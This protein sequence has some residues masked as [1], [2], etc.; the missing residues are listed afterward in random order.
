MTGPTCQRCGARLASSAVDALCAACLLQ[1][2]L[3]TMAED[4]EQPATLR[5]PRD[6]GPYRLLEEIGRGGMGVVYRAEQTGLGRLVAVK[7]LLAGA[8]SAETLLRRFHLEA[9]AIAALQHPN[10]VAIHDYGEV[11]GQP[12]YAM[13]LVEGRDLAA[14]CGGRPLPARAAAENLRLLAEAVHYA[15]QHGILHR[16][17]KP[18]NVLVDTSGRPRIADF[19][20]AKQLGSPEGGTLAG[21][22]LG[23]PSYT[24]PEQASGHGEKIDV[25]SDVYGLG[26]LLY[27]L[28]TGRAPFNAASPTETLRLVLDTDPAPPRLLNPALPAD[29]E[30]ICLKCLEKEPGRRYATAAD[31]A[32]DLQRYLDERPILARPPSVWYRM[33]KF[34]RRHRAGVGMTAAV[35]F[36]LTLGLGLAL[37]G[38]HRELVLRQQAEAARAEAER[39]LGMMMQD[40]KPALEE[41]AA[42]APLV[43]MTEAAVR[44]Y[45]QLPARL[46]NS[47]TDA[48]HADALAALARLR[49]LQNDR[50]GAEAALAAALEL[51]AR[52]A[53]KN[54]QD[55]DAAAAWLRDRWDQ[56]RLVANLTRYQSLEWHGEFYRRWTELHR[57]FPGNARVKRGLAEVAAQYAEVAAFFDAPQESIAAAQLSRKLVGELQAAAPGDASLDAVAFESLRS[58]SSGYGAV[59]DHD[60]MLATAE[61]AVSFCTAAW[62]KDPANLALRRRL[63]EAA[64][65]LSFRAS[66]VSP[67]RACAAERVA[68][69]HFRILAE[70]RPGDMEVYSRYVHAHSM[71]RLYWVNHDGDRASAHAFLDRYEQLLA[72][73]PPAT[74]EFD[75]TELRTAN[76]I[77]RAQ[78]FARAGDDPR[79]REACRAA[80]ASLEVQIDRM[81]ADPMKRRLVRIRTLEWLL[82]VDIDLGDWPGLAR[83]AQEVSDL[84]DAGLQLEPEN[85]ELRVRSLQMPLFRGLAQQGLGQSA[86]AVAILEEAIPRLRGVRP[87]AHVYDLYGTRG[88]AR[89]ALIAA[90]AALGN[91][92]AAREQAE[93][94]L[95]VVGPNVDEG[96]YQKEFRARVQTLLAG[97]LASDEAGR[98]AELLATGEALLTAPEAGPR[99]TQS[100]R[101]T[102]EKI[103]ALR[104]AAGPSTG[105]TVPAGGQSSAAPPE[106]RPGGPPAGI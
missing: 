37:R 24:P 61:E 33:R 45:D 28:L 64:R 68:R 85:A 73:M 9:A 87:T 75:V 39:L 78:L 47:R 22:M 11:D 46:R 20:L 69:E 74:E 19:G 59:R 31:L 17:L 27:H 80:R 10:I 97:V 53:Q 99:L 82:W 79:C 57:R 62:Q 86:E 1:S 103:A 4:G 6:F 98:A 100:G 54:P 65:A 14:L 32:T 7:L 94:L 105:T 15:H 3:D 51:R 16:D 76:C 56:P 8:Y 67:P 2:A 43:Q 12:Y 90:H 88:Q 89:I 52:T 93:A 106:I 66:N 58:L 5:L 30:T 91:T 38:F 101:R 49:G 34:T 77:L 18:S 72:T 60:R 13:E 84:V 83:G 50:A 40:L 102:L 36:A 25:A 42:P 70:A 41:R 104:N 48:A 29:L 44:Y 21:Q 23:S 81:A 96:W 35:I 63:A 71:E 92:R 95:Q 26:A 55:P